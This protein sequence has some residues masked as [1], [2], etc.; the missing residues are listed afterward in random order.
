[1]SSDECQAA[2]DQRHSG[3]NQRGMERPER[4]TARAV[5]PL[6]PATVY[7]TFSGFPTAGLLGHV[8]K[9]TSR[10]ASWADISGNLPNIPVNGIVVDPDLPQA[11]YI[12]TDA[13]VMVTTNGGGNWS[14]LGNGLPRVVVSSLVLHRASRVLRAATHGRS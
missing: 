6:D 13:G 14:S 11:L 8:Y 10:G 12:A 7:V 9:T 5:D 2:H 1:M 4:G 3:P